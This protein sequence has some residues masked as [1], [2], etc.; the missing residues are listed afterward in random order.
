VRPADGGVTEVATPPEEPSVPS[1]TLPAPISTTRR[2]SRAKPKPARPR[3]EVMFELRALGG[4][5][6]E[7]ALQD[8]AA[9]PQA[10]LVAW[11]GRLAAELG[12][13]PAAAP[14]TYRDLMRRIVAA[15]REAGAHPDRPTQALPLAA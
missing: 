7:Q 12:A 10:S 9:R 14:A 1:I 5:V 11:A 15:N 13:P 4:L 2:R 3:A 8:A 6:L